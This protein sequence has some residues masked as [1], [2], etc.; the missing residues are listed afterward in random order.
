YSV[1]AAL[2]L[3]ARRFVSDIAFA[4]IGFLNSFAHWLMLPGLIV[5][6]LAILFRRRRV[7]WGAA[8]PA[9]EFILTYG[10]LYLRQSPT[11][12]PETASFTLMTYNLHAEDVHLAPMVRVIAEMD[13]DIVCLQELSDALAAQLER[14]LAGQYP[15]RALHGTLRTDGQ[16]VLSKFPI[17][18]DRYFTHADIPNRQG[19]QRVVIATPAGDVV[20]YNVH[21]V[22][23]GMVGVLFDAEPRAREVGYLLARVKAEHGIVIMA[24]DMNLN[25]QT[26]VYAEIAAVMSDAYREVGYG[27]GLTFPNWQT[28]QSLPRGRGSP[29]PI[30]LLVRLDHIFYRGGLR[31]LS[32]HVGEDTGGSD[33]HPVIVAFGR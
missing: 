15:Y 10:G 28:P 18:E 12:P 5:L 29:L 4:P 24:G 20:I 7:A 32:A 19:Q 33:H 9:L 30:P 2:F 26:N 14:D 17:R 13:A 25:D 11:L 1:A 31:A 8:L 23:P 3:I 27:L 6:P 16:G 22:H 21:P